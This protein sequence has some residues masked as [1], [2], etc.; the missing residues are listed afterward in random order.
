[1]CGYID[2]TVTRSQNWFHPE[3]EDNDLDHLLCE[4]QLVGGEEK[5]KIC[6]K[7]KYRKEIKTVKD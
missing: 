1:M 7:N 6:E 2:K 4:R 5:T 3:S